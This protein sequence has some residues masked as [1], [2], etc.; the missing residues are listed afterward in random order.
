MPPDR[1]RAGRPIPPG[2]RRRT[3]PRSATQPV[4]TST[5][6]KGGVL[7]DEPGNGKVVW[8]PAISVS[9]SARPSR[10]IAPR[11]RPHEPSAW[12][13]GCRTPEVMRHRS[14]WPFDANAGTGRHHPV[15]DAPGSGVKSRAD[16]RRYADSMRA[17]TDRRHAPGHAQWPR[18]VVH[19]QGEI[20]RGRC[21]AGHELRDAMLPAAA[22][23]TSR[24]RNDPPVERRN[25]AVAAFRRPA[26]VTDPDCE[27]MHSRRA[28]TD[29]TGAGASSQVSGCR[30]LERAVALPIGANPSG[31]V[32]EQFAPRYDE[33]ADLALQ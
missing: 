4:V 23:L 6:R 13:R 25:S 12:P 8:I 30:P 24:N 1:L 26:A 19:R 10:L 17:R 3:I 22:Y 21:P 31:V 33:R 11:D 28:P 7:R 15:A 32:A 29:R 16:P 20:A 14:R 9:P 2:Q 27:L 18:A 5:G